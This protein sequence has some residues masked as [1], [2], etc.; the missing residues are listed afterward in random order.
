[1]TA[2]PPVLPILNHSRDRYLKMMDAP[3]SNSGRDI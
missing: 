3:P 1:M 2:P